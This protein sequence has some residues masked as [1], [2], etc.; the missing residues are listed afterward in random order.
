LQIKLI[1]AELL[2]SAQPP[3]AAPVNRYQTPPA[4]DED[5]DVVEITQFT[6]SKTPKRAAPS[7]AG[8]VVP[9]RPRKT[10]MQV[11][12]TPPQEQDDLEIH[13]TGTIS[14]LLYLF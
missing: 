12:F 3:V 9:K 4:V 11:P 14:V 7:S 8:K 6:P 13:S 5:D 1:V 2:I 10:P